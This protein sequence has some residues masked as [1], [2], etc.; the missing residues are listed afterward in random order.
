MVIALTVVAVLV[1]IYL[2]L[3]F[4]VAALDGRMTRRNKGDRFLGT[5]TVMFFWP[6]SV[7]A[8]IGTL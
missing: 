7:L 3:G 4:T 5:V 1:A 6:I 8:W 2:I